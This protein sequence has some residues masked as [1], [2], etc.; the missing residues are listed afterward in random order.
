MIAIDVLPPAGSEPI[1]H[2]WVPGS[3][4][5]PPLSLTCTQFAGSSS[6]TVTPVAALGPLFV[7]VTV[8]TTCSNGSASALSTVLSTSRSIVGEAAM[9]AS[10]SSSSYGAPS[11]LPGVESTS[12]WSEVWIC[13]TLVNVPST[14]T[15]T[16]RVSEVEAPTAKSPTFQMPVP[17]L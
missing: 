8:Q 6:Y 14:S 12:K 9:T 1:V 17:G 13:A 11:S 7:T 15:F 3:Y 10:S 2:R 5:P 4:A 16:V